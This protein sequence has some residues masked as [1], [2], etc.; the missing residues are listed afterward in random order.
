MRPAL[1]CRPQPTLVAATASL[2][3]KLS[4]AMIALVCCFISGCS[5]SEQAKEQAPTDQAKQQVASSPPTAQEIPRQKLSPLPPPKLNEVEEAV[6]RVFRQ[7]ALIDSSRKTNFIVGDFNGDSSQDIAVVL[8]SAP[9]KVAE[10]NE[11]FPRW[12]LKDPFV[13]SRPGMRPLR[14]AENEVLLAVIH[15]YGPNGWRDPEAT[16]T[17]LLKNAVGPDVAAHLKDDVVA[18]NRGKKLPGFKGDVIGEVLR[19]NSGYLYYNE[20]T[21]SWYDPK[22]FKGEP[23]K[24]VVHP[25][26]TIKTEK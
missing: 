22:T 8:K 17:Y 21:Y 6:K 11:E 5:K 23:E 9:G 24:R 12:I 15:G 3:L 14:V 7:A 2:S 16:Q 18:K 4:L 19:G 13:I 1:T 26:F 10:M 20:A 25:G